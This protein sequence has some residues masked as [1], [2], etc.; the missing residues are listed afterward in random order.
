MQLTD[1]C[2][3]FVPPPATSGEREPLGRRSWIRWLCA[4]WALCEV[5]E[6]HCQFNDFSL[7]SIHAADR[8]DRE[9]DSKYTL[10]MLHL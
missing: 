2:S 3:A 8:T 6:N 7:L 10:F 1:A 5:M 9:C 4:G